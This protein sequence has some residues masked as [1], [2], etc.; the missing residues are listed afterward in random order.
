MDAHHKRAGCRRLPFDSFTTNNTLRSQR[1]RNVDQTRQTTA[2]TAAEDSAIKDKHGERGDVTPLPRSPQ[3]QQQPPLRTTPCFHPRQQ[4]EAHI[5][6][7]PGSQQGG[8]C[9]RWFGCASSS[10]SSRT[11]RLSPVSACLLP[12]D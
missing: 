6:Y 12:P 1:A 11:T 7:P 5:R 3:N 2:T 4:Q 9:C 10:R 8:G